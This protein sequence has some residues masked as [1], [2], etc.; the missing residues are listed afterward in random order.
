MKYLAC[1]VV[2]SLIT[3]ATVASVSAQGATPIKVTGSYQGVNDAG[4]QPSTGWV[5]G[6]SKMQNRW[7]GVE[8]ELNGAVGG[9]DSYLYATQW[10]DHALLGGVRFSRTGRVAPFARVQAGVLHSAISSQ[11][12]AIGAQVGF[13]FGVNSRANSAFVL[14]PGAG[15]VVPSTWRRARR[16][17]TRAGIAACPMKT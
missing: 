14:Q 15:V 17:G 6:I 4:G 10:R 3:V 11:N 7:F 2:W 16:R 5:V 12:T 8:A 9:S 1:G 13:P